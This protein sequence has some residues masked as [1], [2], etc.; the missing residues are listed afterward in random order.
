MKQTPKEKLIQQNLSGSKFALDGFLGNDRR[1][2]LQII[3][4]DLRE[5]EELKITNNEIAERLRYFSEKSFEH[6]AGKVIIDKIYEVEYQSFRGKVICPFKHKG[7]YPKGK[8][9]L[10][11]LNNGIV[12]SWSPLSIHLIEEHG[13]FEGEGS[14]NRLS[15]KMLKEVIF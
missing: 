4:D 10:K 12:I 15:P 13:F 8:I 2:Y 14:N 3:K 11:N 7:V 6:F 9:N 1:D 5:L